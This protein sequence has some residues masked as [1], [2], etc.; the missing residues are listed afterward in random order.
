MTGTVFA[1]QTAL[2]AMVSVAKFVN[3]CV[4]VVY[5]EYKDMHQCSE[6][7]NQIVYLIHI[8]RGHV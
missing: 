5:L 7:V 8:C 6:C 1:L 2:S 4:E 3:A